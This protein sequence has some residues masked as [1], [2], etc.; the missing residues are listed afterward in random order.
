MSWPIDAGWYS[1]TFISTAYEPDMIYA[2]PLT[3]LSPSSFL[4]ALVPFSSLLSLSYLLLLLF[5]VS[6]CLHLFFALCLTSSAFSQFNPP[7]SSPPHPSAPTSTLCRAL[8]PMGI[9]VAK[10]TTSATARRG[11]LMRRSS[12]Q[13]MWGHTVKCLNNWGKVLPCSSCPCQCRPLG[14]VQWT[15][16]ICSLLD[17]CNVIFRLPA[18]ITVALEL[19][20]QLWK[21]L[22]FVW[23]KLIGAVILLTSSALF[24]CSTWNIKKW[25]VP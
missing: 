14:S 1:F 12:W 4:F 24:L 2:V 23:D 21:E 6:P 15:L 3:S 16:E 9:R 13:T 10:Q 5:C 8:C 17:C 20:I 19:Q 11:K 22:F 18:V 25:A 7:L